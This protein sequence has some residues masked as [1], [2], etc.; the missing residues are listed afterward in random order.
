MVVEVVTLDHLVTLVI[1]LIEH[2]MPL[3]H[4]VTLVII[5]TVHPVLSKCVY[6]VTSNTTCLNMI[7]LHMVKRVFR[8]RKKNHFPSGVKC[9]RYRK[10]RIVSDNSPQDEQSA[11]EYDYHGESNQHY[12]SSAW[13][14]KVTD[15]S[16]RRLYA[17]MGPL[18]SSWTVV[19]K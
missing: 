10:V 14:G 12:D 9:P 15:S 1:L 17:T 6:I 13:I 8:V 16:K 18:D 2:K 4:L 11:P 19:P 3:D 7:V 5:Q